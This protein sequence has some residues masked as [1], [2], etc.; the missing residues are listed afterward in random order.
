MHRHNPISDYFGLALLAVAPG[1]LI[2]RRL[3]GLWPVVFTAAAF[4]GLA[5]SIGGDARLLFAAVP[6]LSVAGVWVWIELRRFPVG[7]RRAAVAAIGL[8]L[9]LGAAKALDRPADAF[10]VS[11]GIED[12]ESYLVRCEP[13]YT[14]AVVANHLLR[15]G[16]RILSQDRR[17]FYFDHPTTWIGGDDRLLKIGRSSLSAEEAGA[18]L[19]EAGYTHLLLAEPLDKTGQRGDFPLSRLADADNV[20]TDYRR[21]TADGRPC[22]YRLV[23]LR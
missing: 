19:R 8:M 7:A 1:L 12:R 9:A 13:T 20:L 17:T 4:A 2:V 14:A 3:R 16:A 10:R 22:R 18:L 15:A 5:L 6:L 21:L 23:P 11:L